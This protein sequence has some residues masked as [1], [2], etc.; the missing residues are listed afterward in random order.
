MPAT[1]APCEAKRTKRRTRREE[2]E[3]WGYQVLPSV[4]SYAK[5]Q[6]Q[7][8]CVKPGAHSVVASVSL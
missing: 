4:T 5:T 7:L 8:S 2:H 6:S 1:K 3:Y